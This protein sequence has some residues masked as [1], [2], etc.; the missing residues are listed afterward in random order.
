MYPKIKEELSGEVH[1]DWD[2]FSEKPDKEKCLWDREDLVHATLTYPKI[3]MWSKV[4]VVYEWGHFGKEV[5]MMKIA[6]SRKQDKFCFYRLY[7]IRKRAGEAWQL[8]YLG[9][10]IDVFVIKWRKCFRV[11]ELKFVCLIINKKTRRP[12]VGI[13]RIQRIRG[14]VNK[15]PDWWLKTQKDLP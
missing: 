2:C 8:R 3:K 5:I 10:K 13:I 9:M 14:V 6:N 11:H 4:Y 7:Q 12:T 1:A 15:F